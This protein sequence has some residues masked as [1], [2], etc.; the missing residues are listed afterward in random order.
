[1]QDFFNISQN[2]IGLKGVFVKYYTD[3]A[4]ERFNFYFKADDTEKIN[5]II[6]RVFVNID[7]EEKI[8]YFGK[9]KGEYI[10]FNISSE[11]TFSV[12][13]Q[14]AYCISNEVK[15]L[16]TVVNDDLKVFIVGLG[17]KSIVCDSLGSLVC[18]NVIVNSSNKIN[19]NLVSTFCPNVEGKTG[20]DSFSLVKETLKQVGANALIM[21][22]SFYALNVSRLGR[23]FQLSN[24]G[25]QLKNNEFTQEKLGVPVIVLGC[26]FAIKV[27]TVVS[28]VL[29][30]LL[31]SKKNIK[32]HLENLKG[33]D[34]IITLLDLNDKIHTAAKLIATSINMAI[35][36]LEFEDV[37]IP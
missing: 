29:D 24:G 14:L 8:R 10:C 16:L 35:F 33:E 15:K 31:S 21:V 23:S 28:K 7:S 13:R 22:D 26:P 11:L 34:N 18:D 36:D 2:K 19:K 37:F 30:E 9:P 12:F 5:N 4:F 17:N 20:V 6:E 1:M 27:E 3:M 25:L 32:M